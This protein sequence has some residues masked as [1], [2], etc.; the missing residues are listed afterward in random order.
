MKQETRTR[1]ARRASELSLWTADNPEVTTS[2]HAL[3]ATRLLHRFKLS[4]ALAV[5]LA[6]L[7]FRNGREA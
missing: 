3:Q 1:G 5:A 4:P 7:A 2:T 6:E